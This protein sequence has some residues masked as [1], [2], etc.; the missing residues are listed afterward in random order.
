[1]GNIKRNIRIFLDD[2]RMPEF[3]KWPVV[4]TVIVRNFDDFKL[5]VIRHKNNLA[6]ISFDHDL[7]L[8][9]KT[10]YDCATWIEDQIYYGNLS[11]NIFLSCHSMNISGRIRINQV[12]TA[13]RNRG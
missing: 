1:M 8:H 9:N 2:E 6:H 4:G 10:G 13:I 3:I 12:I 5:E 7:G 11:P